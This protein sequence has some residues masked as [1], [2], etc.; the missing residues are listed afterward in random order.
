MSERARSIAIVLAVLI[1]DR[2]TKYYIQT[3]FS[4]HDIYVVIP[5]VFNIVHV[6]NPGAAFSLL[7]DAPEAVRRAILIGLSGAVMVAIGFLLF[8]KQH[9]RN[10][11]SAVTMTGLALVLGGALGNF[12]DRVG[13]GTVTDF[14]Q[15]FLG[16]YEYPSFNVADSA[17][18]CGA[19][20]LILDILR[21]RR[22]SPAAA[23]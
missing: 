14:I 11:E 4:L 10:R 20:L 9:E 17:V 2:I 8:R 6:E 22:N 1:L 23:K 13:V 15:V 12:W 5:N 7:A 3:N 18:F 21:G 16:S 19:V